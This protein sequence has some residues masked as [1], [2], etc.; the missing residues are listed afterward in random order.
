[1]QRCCLLSDAGTIHDWTVHE[2]EAQNLLSM[3]VHT[4]VLPKQ[5]PN[6]AGIAN[7]HRETI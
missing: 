2:C 5:S 6:F 7:D 1:M 3:Y 4:Y